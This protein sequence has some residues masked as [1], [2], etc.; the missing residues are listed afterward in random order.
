MEESP[1]EN[2]RFL[3]VVL[4]AI[5]DGICVLDRDMTVLQVNKA[6]EVMYAHALPLVGRK[7]YRNF[8]QKDS[9]CDPCPAWRAFRDKT[10]HFNEVPYVGPAGQQGWLE[11][12]SFPIMDQCGEVTGVVEHIR[13]ITSRKLIELA[14]Q[15]RNHELALLQ[16]VNQVLNS[17][18]D[19]DQVLK[20]VLQEVDRW[21]EATGSAIW[22]ADLATGDLVCR[23][24]T[25][26]RAEQV[27]SWRLAPGQGL[28]GWTASHGR[29]LMVEDA[30]ADPRHFDKV[31]QSTGLA[32]RSV[33]TAPLKAKGGVLGALQVV[34]IRPGRFD[35]SHLDFLEL[36]ATSAATAI[37]NA[38]LFEQSQE[39][40]A[41]R[42][43]LEM[44]KVAAESASRAKSDFLANMSHEIRTPLNGIIGLTELALNTALDDKQ[45]NLM[46]TI[47]SEATSLIG[48]ISDILDFSKIEAEKLELE[49]IPFD[50]GYLVEDVANGVAFGAEKKGLEFISYLA[51]NVSARL[52]GDPGRLRQVL[53]NLTG[54]ALKFTHQGEILLKCEKIE[55]MGDRIKLRFLV[56]DTGIGIPKEKQSSIFDVFTQVD[57]STT[58]K[59]GGTGLGTA[60]SKRLVELIGG[61]I[62]VESEEGR[63]ST[64]WFTLVLAKQTGERPLPVHIEDGLADRR[65]L[66][67]DDNATYRGVLKDYLLSWQGQV[68]EATSAAEALAILR[69][70]ASQK[71]SFDLLL[72]DV[73]M[74]HADGFDLAEAVRADE[75]WRK[76]KIMV[77]ST[78]GRIGDGRRCREL[79]IEGYLTKPIRRD[80][81]YKAL[82]SVLHPASGEAI[83]DRTIPVTRHTIS[84]AERKDVRILLVED[85]PTN[86]AVALEHLRGAGYHVDLAEDGRQ[87]V[88][89][90]K[91]RRYDLILMDIQ[92]PVMD[93]LAATRAIRELSQKMHG[94]SSQGVTRPEWTPIAAMTA[95]VVKG[96]RERFLAAGMDDYLSKPLRRKDLLTLVQKWTR[97]RPG[98]STDEPEPS[99]PKPPEIIGKA[100]DLDAPMDYEKALEEFMGK[101]EVLRRV[102]K[103]FLQNARGQ[104]GLIRQALAEGRAETVAREAH[105][106]KG[107][108]AN[109]TANDLARAALEIENMGRSGV[110]TSAEE[111]VKRLEN[112]LFVLEMFVEE[113]LI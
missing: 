3:D 23:Q 72:T 92:M 11:L 55:D 109:L 91:K 79:G 38:L 27:R 89:A 77:I 113:R 96:D 100:I 10:P 106:I 83:S 101:E 5:Q 24:A 54:N 20:A 81:L 16:Q 52:I 39:H 61:E 19:L 60:I 110:L 94:V 29:S 88:E 28:V 41:D 104:V 49:N 82:I 102:L 53:M 67:V 25:G 58:R 43:K 9:R 68:T 6:M 35:A 108:A 44:A 21:M 1:R 98:D 18:L 17:I 59:Y 2:E 63:G 22:L 93:G 64:F 46:E 31:D 84:E 42:L 26:P 74:P 47:Y 66:I 4:N 78:L 80:D 7:C 69:H 50:L 103:E 34:D 107:G 70:S 57:S 56:R 8:H 62:G 111:A 85:Y 90:F 36:L 99:S 65:I 33:L 97:T 48:L 76:T 30:L 95:N 105:S 40:L 15:R 75:A 87:A 112:E 51:P 45:R 14:L 86:Q 13:D 12:Y 71:E 32:T 73:Q 37:D